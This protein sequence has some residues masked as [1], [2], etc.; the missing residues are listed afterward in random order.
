MKSIS[1]YITAVVGLMAIIGALWT[2]D[3]TYTRAERTD[4]IEQRLDRKIAED[5][6]FDLRRRQWALQEHYGEVKAKAMQEYK[7][8]ENER[9]KILRG[10]KK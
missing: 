1:V 4:Q 10:L 6:A 2:V 5:K 7:E 9:E 3:S 8:L